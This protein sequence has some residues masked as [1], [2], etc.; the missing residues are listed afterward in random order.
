[1][2]AIVAKAIATRSQQSANQYA[3]AIAN[4]CRAG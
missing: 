1:M 3:K 4:D 2:N